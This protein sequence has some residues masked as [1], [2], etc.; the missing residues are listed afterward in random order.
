MSNDRRTEPPQELLQGGTAAW[1]ASQDDPRAQLEAELVLALRESQIATQKMDET[2]AGA[3]GLTNPTDWRCLDII[4]QRGRITAGQLAAEAGLTT[5]AITAVLDRLEQHG[6]ARRVADP[7]DRR[8]VLVEVTEEE[9]E[10][11]LRLYWPLKDMAAEW[12]DQRSDEELRLLVDYHRVSAA[13]NL[14]RAAEIRAELEADQG[15]PPA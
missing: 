2:A 13:I 6:Y 1:V 10:A 4:D 5:G 11:A 9:R 3:L 14:R 8:R 12:I 7:G 15:G